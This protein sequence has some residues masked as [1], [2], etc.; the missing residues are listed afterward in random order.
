MRPRTEALLALGLLGAVVVVAAAIGRRREGTIE[1][2]QRRSTYLTGPSGT[3]GLADALERLGVEVER[4]RQPLRRAREATAGDPG[5]VFAMLD[6][7]VRSSAAD[8]R[9]LSELSADPDSGADLLLA[10][11]ELGPAM[12]CFGYTVEYRG[13]ASVEAVIPGASPARPAPWV[14]AVLAATTDTVVTD[15]GE[16]AAGIPQVCAVAPVARAE[17]LLVTRTG[18][19]VAVRLTRADLD[20]RVVLVADG[21]LF[22]NRVLR[23]TEAGPLLLGLLAGRYRRVVFDE[24]IHGFTA[25]GSLARAVLDWSLRS[26]LGWAAWQ[27][28]AVG[29]LA[30][31]AGAVRF[32]RPRPVI[33]RRRRSPLEH[34][35][36]L[37]TALAAAQG[38]DVAIGA[39]VQ[40]L[41]RRL[42][43]PGQ[44]TRADWRAWVAELERQARSPRAREAI[45]TLTTL[46]RPGQPSASVLRAAN[47]VEDVWEAM[48]S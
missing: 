44:R 2:D 15:S 22:S 7:E 48:R 36:A 31:L 20:R 27:L 26:P 19:V 38:H 37:A 25:G 40:G 46:T 29:F 3:R 6:P 17:T 28:A 39:V 47:A 23:S 34:V 12:A 10:G 14:N 9:L 41:R 24:Q 32:G 8:A 45:R 43:P 11:P 5:A 13:P 1:E 21:L 30:L 42:L 16:V 18:R 4:F 35:R 33:P